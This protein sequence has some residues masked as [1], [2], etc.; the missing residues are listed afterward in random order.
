LAGQKT[1]ASGC[2]QTPEMLKWATMSVSSVKLDDFPITSLGETDYLRN[3]NPPAR[4]TDFVT[5]G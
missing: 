5:S 4:N 1:V 3:P 2:G